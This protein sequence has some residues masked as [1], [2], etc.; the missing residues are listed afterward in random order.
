M[1]LLEI[2][3]G[4]VP[5][6]IV[7]TVERIETRVAR[8]ASLAGDNEAAHGAEDDLYIDVLKHIAQGD[9][10]HAELARAALKAADIPYTRW[11]A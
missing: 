7:I 2:G 1:D 9:D 4:A 11:Y 6:R 10:E 3:D 5:V 8:I